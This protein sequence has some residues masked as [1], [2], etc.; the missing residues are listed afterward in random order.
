LPIAHAAQPRDNAKPAVFPA[1][2]AYNL[3]KTKLNLPADFAGQLDLL[4]IS[5]QP[6]QQTQIQTWLSTAQGL[7]H[8][9]FNLHW[10]RLPISTR[11]NIVFRWWDDSSMRSDESDPEIWPWIIPLY[12]DKD[13]FR[14]SLHIPSDK[15]V[16]VLLINKQGKVLWRADG[17]LT[18]EKR[19]A[20]Q[21]AVAAANK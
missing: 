10:Y 13:G 20:L 6:E 17:P 11:E 16:A 1:L 4:L 2:T 18:P 21:A 12:I 7:Q 9:N 15:Q 3:A 8:T 19:T 5:F 14:H